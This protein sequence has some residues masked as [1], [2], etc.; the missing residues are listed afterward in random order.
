ME[1][2]ILLK[3]FDLQELIEVVGDLQDI[4]VEVEFPYCI[5]NSNLF[6]FHPISKQ[7]K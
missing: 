4:L 5:Y 7:I 2:L 1:R 6:E 3:S